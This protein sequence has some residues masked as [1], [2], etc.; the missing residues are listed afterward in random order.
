M[1][2]YVIESFTSSLVTNCN[3]YLI[4]VAT[5]SIY[6]LS[7]YHCCFA[8]AVNWVY[9]RYTKAKMLLALMDKMK[10]AP[11]SSKN[12][13]DI[14]SFVINDS[15]ISA[16]VSYQQLGSNYTLSVPYCRKYVAPMSQYKAEL[17]GSETTIITQQPGVP[18]LVS[19]EEL[20]G[21][22]IR[23]TNEETNKQYEYVLDIPPMY[24]EE[25]M[26]FE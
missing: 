1:S 23:I 13:K 2:T 22:L 16:T 18:Y 11:E 19:A 7:R 3:P 20:G 25:V 6:G 5:I 24:A 14:P 15:D 12:V 8:N 21:D 26:D 10:N 17:V 4:F 9:D